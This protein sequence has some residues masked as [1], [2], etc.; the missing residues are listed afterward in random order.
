M[1]RSSAQSDF[2]VDRL[3]DPAAV[4][5][6]PPVAGPV[7]LPRAELRSTEASAVATRW[8]MRAT[9]LLLLALLILCLV[10]PHIPAGE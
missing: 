9:L 1:P 8:V 7:S 3:P 5:E 2:S 6:L 10:G 4:V